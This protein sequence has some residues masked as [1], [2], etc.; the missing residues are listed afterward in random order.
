MKE[1]KKG[2]YRLRERGSETERES[3]KERVVE[4]E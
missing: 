1:G 2:I 3:E 4:N